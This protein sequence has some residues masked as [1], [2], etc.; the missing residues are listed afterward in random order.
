MF[1]A[2]Y[3]D[4]EAGWIHD[5]E[6]TTAAKNTSSP[7]HGGAARFPLPGGIPFSNSN[8]QGALS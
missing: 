1:L 4:E 3:P 6:L 8:D 2:S 5:E 7:R